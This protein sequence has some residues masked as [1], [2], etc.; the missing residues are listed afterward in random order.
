[1]PVVFINEWLPNPSGVD[2]AGE[3]VELY[4]SGA[5][6]ISTKGFVLATEK[7][8]K[9]PLPSRTITA[10][11]YA[12]F[13]KPDLAITLRNTDGGLSLYNANG[14]LIDAAHFLGSA[15]EGKSFSRVNYSAEDIVHFG[16]VDP[17]PGAE[18]K[19]IN[20]TIASVHYPTGS[21]LNHRLAG[22]EFVSL[23]FGTALL[24]T[25]LILYI[26]EKNE[27]LSKLIFG[28]DEGTGSDAGPG[29]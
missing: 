26:I 28:G 19:T 23:V 15:P 24:L 17:T 7:G 10:N 9:F 25:G 27:D 13:K 29:I 3:F 1:M 4:N 2:A 22:T 12:V 5:S 11:G 8:K 16:F 6:S 18:N 21:A 14:R 20:T